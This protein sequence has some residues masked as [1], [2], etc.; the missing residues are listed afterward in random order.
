MPRWLS[1]RVPPPADAAF[2]LPSRAARRGALLLPLIAACTLGALALLQLP[3]LPDRRWLLAPLPAFALLF[4]RRWPGRASLAALLAAAWLGA[5]LAGWQAQRLID[6]R[7]PVARL[8]ETLDVRG[9][10]V[11]LP[12]GEAIESAGGNDDVVAGETARN[13]HFLFE[14]EDG[15]LPHRIRV[16]WYRS[17]ERPRG[18]DCWTLRLR[19]RPPH[20]SLDPGGFDYEGWLFRQGIAATATVQA[21]HLAATHRATGCCARGSGSPIASRP[22]C[23]GTRACCWSRR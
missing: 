2:P 17:H 6:E 3:A 15:S 13:W 5:A 19:L 16:A 12:Q 21:V 4:V 1:T 11:S 9:A 22:G 7:W 8:G 20:G 23:P 10:I 14:P 18:G